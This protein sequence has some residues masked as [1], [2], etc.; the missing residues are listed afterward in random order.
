MNEMLMQFYKREQSSVFLSCEFQLCCYLRPEEVWGAEVDHRPGSSSW[1][2][3][4]QKQRQKLETWHYLNFCLWMLA[5]W[6]WFLAGCFLGVVL[7]WNLEYADKWW[8]LVS[9][10]CSHINR[11]HTVAQGS[12]G[13]AWSGGKD[14]RML[15]GRVHETESSS[16]RWRRYR[17]LRILG[18]YSAVWY[19]IIHLGLQVGR[20][21]SS[22]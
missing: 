1:V 16:S 2:G 21:K 7:Y 13:V 3:D 5:I 12:H 4:L 11:F 15:V 10:L 6:V 14:I 17:F 18:E 20:Q 19:C 22:K 8:S 9:S